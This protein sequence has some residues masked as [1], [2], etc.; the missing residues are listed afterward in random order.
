MFYRVLKSL[1][2]IIA[3][4]FLILTFVVF[5]DISSSLSTLFVG[6]VTYIQFVPSMLGFIDSISLLFSG[7]IL[8]LVLTILFGRIYCS[9]FCPL[10]IIQDV[11]IYLKRKF[12]RKKRFAYLKP[13]NRVRYGILVITA[14]VLITGSAFL[15]IFLDPYSLFGK[16]N[17]TVIK[18]IL[19]GINNLISKLLSSWF[20]IYSVYPVEL[21]SVSLSALIF[22]LLFTILL[23]WLTLRYARLYCNLICPVGT[24]LGLPSKVSVFRI[25]LDQE[26]CTSCGRCSA[27]CKTG[28]IDVF[29]RKVDHSRCI[30]CFNCLTSC[31]QNGVHY[32]FSLSRK[33]ELPV[34]EAVNPGRRGFLATTLGLM[35]TL[36]GSEKLFAQQHRRRGKGKGPV[37]VEK[38]Y[39]V[40]PPGSL[41]IEHF[42]DNCTACYLCVSACPTQVLQP[43]WLTYGLKGI[44]Q[45]HMDYSTS[46]CNFD[47]T[48]CGEACPTGAILPLNQQVK[49]LTQVGIVKFIKQNCIVYTDNTDCGACSEHC[50]TKAVNMKPWRQGL[51]LPYVTPE[52]CIGCGAC[53]YAC[54][55]TPK[56]IYVDGNPVHV[57]AEK[58]KIEKLEVESSEDFPF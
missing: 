3:L 51:L 44:L 50:P 32:G 2:V 30:V 6:Y 21:R 31:N 22:S 42:N 23:L 13:H 55:T 56:S 47:C 37:P 39:P 33:K 57:L 10:G 40:T 29:N 4:I 14:G 17:V 53:E 20:D 58:P 5:L 49:Q 43:G 7:F 34:Q 48:R 16:I 45:P 18:P 9:V 12:T 27:A 19:V 15:L 41:S 52:I 8:V 26:L 24:L 54:P 1:R 46:F 25:K 28:C 38:N 36:A 35:A 11:V